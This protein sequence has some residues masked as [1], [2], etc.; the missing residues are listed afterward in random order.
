M[1]GL[2]GPI[3]ELKEFC[4]QNN[5]RLLEDAKQLRELWWEYYGSI[6][7]IG[8]FSFDFAKM[9]TCGEEA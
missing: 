3:N 8:M 2:G 9:I 4:L 7:D 6:G 1:L 5:I